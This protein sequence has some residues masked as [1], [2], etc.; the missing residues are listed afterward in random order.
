MLL[1]AA[2]SNQTQI[3]VTMR[4]LKRRLTVLYIGLFLTT[5][6]VIAQDETQYEDGYTS[7][8]C[9]Q[10]LP[11]AKRPVVD[12]YL[13]IDEVFLK[14]DTG[15]IVEE[16]VSV[17]TGSAEITRNEQQVKADVIEYDQKNHTAD[18]GGDV[19]YWDH[20]IYL[21]SDEAFLTFDND[22]GEFKN[23]RYVLIESRGRGTAEEMEMQLGKRT[24]L[25]KLEHTICDLN[26]EFWKLTATDLTLDYENDQGTAKHAVLK[27]YNIPVFYT[28]YISFPLGKERKTGLLTPTYGK[29]NRYGYE[30]HT[31]YYWNIRP[32][33]DAT[34]TPRFLTRGGAAE[35]APGI[36]L[37]SVAA[38]YRYINKSGN[39]NIS[40]E[41]F[42]E[43]NSRDGRH[44]AALNVRLNQRFLKS[45]NIHVNYNHVSD[46]FYLEDFG[47]QL[48][49]ASTRFVSQR[50]DIRYSGDRWNTAV[51]VQNY[52]IVDQNIST[53]SRPY[54]QLPQ[55]LFNYDS[56]RENKHINYGLGSEAVYFYRGEDPAIR[57][58]LNGM[59]LHLKPYISYPINTRAFFFTPLLRLDY[60]QYIL[61]DTTQYERS[62]NRTL[63][64]LSLDSGIFLE[65]E[66]NFFNTDFLHTLEPRLY[67]LYIPYRNQDDIPVFDTGSSYT[68]SYSSLF[69]ENR[70]TGADRLGD[71]NQLTFALTSRFVNRKTGKNLGTFRVGQTMYFS[72]RK[73]TLQN[74]VGADETF[75]TVFATL[76][77][78]I[79]R[80]YLHSNFEFDPNTSK[81]QIQKFQAR[82]TYKSVSNRIVNLAYYFRPN[83]EQ[84]DFSFSWPL[85][86][87]WSIVG[88]WNYSI[89]RSSALE[90]FGGVLYNGCCWGL[91]IAG[92]RFLSS[93][94]KFENGIFVDL[95]LKELAGLGKKAGTL[96]KQQIPGY[97]SEF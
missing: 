87:N 37:A 69:R 28:P 89:S 78:N 52:Q 25:Q 43:D 17:L 11:V 46:R 13:D 19:N 71:A 3:R 1:Y 40:A 26:D 77:S 51:N 61:Q 7:R 55:I 73:V 39:G 68:S 49:V 14:A 74:G 67:Y 20:D 92:R 18:L 56:K 24:Y 44:R 54:R 95:E 48:S 75:S 29:T 60:T 27:I 30:V 63:P 76:S 21:N 38:E 8:F 88:R 42:P 70:F 32:D 33:M 5:G 93:N 34:L 80:W 47:G 91:R 53:T 90:M 22:T 2:F 79:D 57:N 16:G 58:N 85:K 62:I 65:K 96:I 23:A 86:N 64:I 36:T 45:G 12:A 31:P 97:Q 94:N 66:M 82:A 9:P 10:P 35:L 41:Y 59:R 83:S 81:N 84:S 50:A 72:D 4:F 15:D 6:T